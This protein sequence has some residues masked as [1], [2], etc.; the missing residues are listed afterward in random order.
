MARCLVTGHKG[1][2]GSRLYQELQNQGHEV[3]GIDLKSTAGDNIL[4]R[5]AGLRN[6]RGVTPKFVDF[7]PEYIFHLACVPRVAY[8]VE[9]PVETME[10]NVL[11]GSIVLDFARRVGAKRVI[12]SSSS[13]VV[14]NGNGPAS[15]YGLQK[16]VTEMECKLYAELYGVDTVGLRYFN[17]Y[18]EDQE[19]DGPYATAVANW[20]H[21][22]RQNKNPFITGTGDQ[23]RDMLYVHDAVAANIFCMNNQNDFNGNHYDVGTGDNISLNEMKEIVANYN[24]NVKFE[25]RSERPGDV[26]YTKADTQPLTDLGWRTEVTINEGLNRCFKGVKND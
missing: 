11:A 25:Y 10:N 3:M 23:R 22:I 26:M 4:Y 8:S 17:V 20:M 15:P 6:V 24:S 12:Y 16:L 13:S 7:A 1:Y 19:V 2:I 18:S 14:G 21:S 5:S 9:Y